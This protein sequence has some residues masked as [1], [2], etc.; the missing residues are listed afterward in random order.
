MTEI[1]AHSRLGTLRDS[2]L[3]GERSLARH[4]RRRYAAPGLLCLLGG[5]A[6]LFGCGISDPAEGVRLDLTALDIAPTEIEAQFDFL[7]RS[8]AVTAARACG[9]ALRAEVE[10]LEAGRWEVFAGRP[11]KA[12]EDWSP[13]QIPAGGTSSGS[14][15][16]P[17]EPGWTYRIAVSYGTDGRQVLRRALSDSFYV[18]R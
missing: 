18:P 4:A 7:N 6:L 17:V 10:R 2:G 3:A 14:L 5:V 16:S 13:V 1:R 11:C 8:D 12:I 15:G 9:G